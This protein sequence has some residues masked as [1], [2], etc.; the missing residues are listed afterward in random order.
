MTYAH[1]FHL[2]LRSIVIHPSRAL[3]ALAGAVALTI[4]G[5]SPASAAHWSHDDAV[6]DVQSQTDTFN[7]ET[8]EENMGEP[9]GAPDNTDTDVIRVGVSHRTQR[10]VLKT[11]LRDV[12]VNSGVVIYDIRTGNRRYSVLQRLGTDRMFPAF[13][14]SRGNGDRVRCTGVE[15]SVDRAVNRAT[16]SIPRRCV[17]SPGWVRVGVGAA[18]LNA[19]ETSFTALLDDAMQD[20]VVRDEL[21]LS[22]RVVRG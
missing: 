22:P 15:R 4:T 21:A 18:K 1:A 7:E 12:T 19:T 6:G 20:A 17:G 14:I 16:V 5:M 2:V 3:A 11:T 9:T 13:H 8:G 10:V